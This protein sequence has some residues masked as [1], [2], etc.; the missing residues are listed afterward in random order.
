MLCLAGTLMHVT[1]KKNRRFSD[2]LS[3]HF[4][5]AETTRVDQR[6]REIAMIYEQM[7]WEERLRNDPRVYQCK[8]T[9]LIPNGQEEGSYWEPIY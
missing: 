3:L 2:T 8:L 6:E 9:C 5:L 7:C 4:Y 1:A